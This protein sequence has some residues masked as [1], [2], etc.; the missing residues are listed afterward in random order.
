[1]AFVVDARL[2]GY[3]VLSVKTGQS[4][5][6]NTYK[7]LSLFHDG[8]TCEVSCTNPDFFPTIDALAELDAIDVDVLCV[9]GRERS[10]I[11]MQSAPVTSVRGY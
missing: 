4:K 3:K 2:S 8:R 6:G 9:A 1:M 7:V 10:Y 5:K 11:T